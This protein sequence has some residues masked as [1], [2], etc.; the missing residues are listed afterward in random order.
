MLEE[1]GLEADTEV[2]LLPVAVL[3]WREG[4]ILSVSSCPAPEDRA[5]PS[6]QHSVPSEAHTH[7]HSKMEVV[8][9]TAQSASQQPLL[10]A[11]FSGLQTFTHRMWSRSQSMG[12]SR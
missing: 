12:L 9:L 6:E 8:C 4:N 1:G 2:G 5:L 11:S 3:L 10:T 7:R